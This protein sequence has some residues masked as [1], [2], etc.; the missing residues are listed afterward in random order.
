MKNLI[1]FLKGDGKMVSEVSIMLLQ[2]RVKNYRS[3][4]DEI[5]IDFTAGSGRELSHFLIERNKVKILPVVSLYG[6][7]A[8]GKSNIIE[9]MQQMF[10]NIRNS[11]TYDDKHGQL[12][13]PFLYEDSKSSEPTEYEMFF[14]IDKYEYQYGFIVAPGKVHEEWLY[15]KLLSV[16]ETKQNPIFVRNGDEIQ[17]AKAYSHLI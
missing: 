10:N 9:A 3:I 4:G 6:S 12:T 8:S 17:F 15:R 1:A 2:F 11:H 7:N 5:T 16:N 14:V 13:T